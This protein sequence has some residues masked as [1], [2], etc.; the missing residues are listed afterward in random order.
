MNRKEVTAE[1]MRDHEKITNTT[2][3]RLQGEYDRERRKRKINPSSDYVKVYTIKTKAKNNWIIIIRK[4][5]SFS[6]YK[7]IGDT[8]Y[9]LITYYHDEKGLVVLRHRD[10]E[11]GIE[12]YWG[13]FFTRYNQRMHLNLDSTTEIITTFFINSG[14]IAYHIHP[15]ENFRTAGI[16]RDG[17]VFGSKDN[18]NN[19]IINKTF[20]S[21]AIAFDDQNKAGQKIVQQ[22]GAQLLL[23]LFDEDSDE[24][25]YLHK[26][27]MMLSFL[28][29]RKT[30]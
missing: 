23:Q 9:C 10:E 8:C 4:P 15:E 12:A 21:K 16:C 5:Y 7:S 14:S 22:F 27:D 18:E 3:V 25:E 29:K 19:W 28:D 17:F 2:L 30:A 20:I 24:R 11:N 1:F 26:A 6:K 13:H